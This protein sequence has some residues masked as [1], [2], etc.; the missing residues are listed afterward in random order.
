M[1]QWNQISGWLGLFALTVAMVGIPPAVTSTVLE[2]GADSDNASLV[3]RGRYRT[4]IYRGTGRREIV[5]MGRG[6]GRIGTDP[7]KV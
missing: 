6:S 1:Q 4:R 2:V 7:A 3:S 5:A